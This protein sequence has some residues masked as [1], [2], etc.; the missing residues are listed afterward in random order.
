MLDQQMCQLS[1]SW[2]HFKHDHETNSQ[3]WWERAHGQE[4]RTHAFLIFWDFWAWNPKSCFWNVALDCHLS[5]VSKMLTP[6]RCKMSGISK[7]QAYPTDSNRI[8]PVVLLILCCIIHTCDI[9]S[10]FESGGNMPT[11]SC[12]ILHFSSRL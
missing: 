2:N 1:I 10:A 7:L 11:H 6:N 8:Y 5:S 3:S 12:S 4:S 9:T